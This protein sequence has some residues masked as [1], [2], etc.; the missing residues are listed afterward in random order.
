[1]TQ[2]PAEARRQLSLLKQHVRQTL[3]QALK[4]KEGQ[5]LAVLRNLPPGQELTLNLH[6]E[7]VPKTRGS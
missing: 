1:M 7:V 4:D 2:D 5:L 3:E 6:L